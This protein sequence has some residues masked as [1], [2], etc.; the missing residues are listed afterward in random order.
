[1]INITLLS[2][3]Q[4]ELFD[5]FKSPSHHSCNWGSFRVVLGIRNNVY[6]AL[7]PVPAK[8]WVPRR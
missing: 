7:D 8:S 5:L 6:T 4:G 1:M 3:L 2:S